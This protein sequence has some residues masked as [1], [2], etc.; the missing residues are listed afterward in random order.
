[1]AK[2]VLGNDPFAPD[3]KTPETEGETAARASKRSSKAPARTG[4]RPPTAKPAI[5][6]RR[7]PKASRSVPAPEQAVEVEAAV[8]TAMAPAPV[9]V[10]FPGISEEDRAGVESS[11][12]PADLPPDV[13]RPP[14]VPEGEADVAAAAAHGRSVEERIRELE[15]QLDRLLEQARERGGEHEVIEHLTR[16]LHANEPPSEAEALAPPARD[17]QNVFD[18]ARELLS[19][20][21]YRRQWGRVALRDRSEE[22]DEFGLDPKFEARWRTFF[23]F[24]FTRWWRVEVHD[25]E[26]VPA[27]G[28]VI[29]CA[30]H[31]GALPYDGAML[32]TALRREHPAHRELRW[33]AEDFVFHFPFLGVF[34]NRIGAVRAC[35]ENAE[36]LLK[37]DACVGVFPEGVKGI[38]KLYRDRYKL[39]RFGR[40]GHVK[41]A[42][43][44]R[45]PIVPVA[46]VGGEETHPMIAPGNALAKLLGVPYVPITPTFPL[47][48]PLGLV[49]LPS[50][51]KMFFL[52]PIPMDG[53]PPEAADDDVLVGRL[54]EKI[55]A[56]IQEELDQAVRN[57]KSVF[58]G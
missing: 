37:K 41:L 40:G 12:A 26:R 38:S 25:I 31:S 27:A 46:I 35:Q 48:G 36:R 6:S 4:K 22:V 33:L 57:R 24:M 28:R 16:K 44:T 47:L 43:R 3:E 54:N 21:Y 10:E 2:R 14:S 19:S 55:R 58:R 30:N 32:A 20:D 56:L 17:E 8:E 29:L 39:Q 13:S 45:T 50:R 23:D 49:P 15:A 18:V 42:I 1:M 52:D 51:W 53:Y 5:P 34:M 7:P 9:P 11:A